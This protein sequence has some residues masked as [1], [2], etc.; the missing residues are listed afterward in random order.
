MIADV[1]HELRTPL[2]VIQGNLRA[3]LDDVYPLTKAEI[4]T[5]YDESVMLSR[6]V[7]DLREL[8]QAEAR[9]RAARPRGG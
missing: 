2:T 9:Q 6:L 8:A 7:G 5:I 1:A 4:A 3:I